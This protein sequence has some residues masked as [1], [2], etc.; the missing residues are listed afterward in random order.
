MHAGKS[1][2]GRKTYSRCSRC[3]ECV[4]SSSRLS[5]EVEVVRSPTEGERA[6]DR[7]GPRSRDGE[8]AMTSTGISSSSWNLR[9]ST[10][11]RSSSFLIAS[12]AGEESTSDGDM[13][14][15]DGDST[16]SHSHPADDETEV[17]AKGLEGDVG[18]RRE[19]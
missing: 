7:I 17:W 15:G 4:G 19:P 16:S 5:H 18:D 13:P 9:A 12:N 11:T 2:R 6:G 3:E 14:T 1:R 10:G 8:R